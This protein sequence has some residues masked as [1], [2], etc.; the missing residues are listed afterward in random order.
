MNYF[1]DREL[2]QVLEEGNR[3]PLPA[4]QHVALITDSE[5]TQRKDRTALKASAFGLAVFAFVLIANMVQLPT[6]VLSI[7]AATL[8]T[9]FVVVTMKGKTNV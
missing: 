7:F 6:I 2:E 4:S 8:I 1:S 3:Q 5:T 9:T